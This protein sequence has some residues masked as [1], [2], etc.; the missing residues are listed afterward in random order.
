M[1]IHYDGF[2]FIGGVN[3]LYTVISYNPK[4]GNVDQWIYTVGDYAYEMRNALK[5]AGRNAIVKSRRIF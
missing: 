3:M 2:F 5:L 1:S 4:T